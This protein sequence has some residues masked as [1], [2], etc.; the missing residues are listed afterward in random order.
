MPSFRAV[1]YLCYGIIAY[2]VLLFALFT[3]IVLSEEDE[4]EFEFE[5]EEEFED[6]N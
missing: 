5:L 2:D 6:W 4:F 3:L 1:F